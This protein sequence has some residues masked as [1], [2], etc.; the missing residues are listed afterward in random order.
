[1]RCRFQHCGRTSTPRW[2]HL[3]MGAFVEQRH[4]LKGNH[5]LLVERRPKRGDSIEDQLLNVFV[6]HGFSSA[7][8]VLVE[9]H[10]L[11]ALGKPPI[12]LLERR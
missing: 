6:G 12:N 11:Y 7:E 2:P 10:I 8:N 4:F 3:A 9:L 1:M 5:P